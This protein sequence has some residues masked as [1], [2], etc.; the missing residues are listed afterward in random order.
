MSF[1]TG[2]K[3]YNNCCKHKYYDNFNDNTRYYIYQRIHEIKIKLKYN[4]IEIIYIKLNYNNKKTRARE[5]VRAQ[6]FLQNDY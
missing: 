1:T 5:G 6:S 3:Y 4:S 2:I